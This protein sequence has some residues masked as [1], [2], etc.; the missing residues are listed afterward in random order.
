[1]QAYAATADA[2]GLQFFATIA[3][4]IP[5][6]AH[7][8]ALRIK[9]VLNNL[10]SNAIKFTEAGWVRIDLV[11][12]GEAD[13]GAVLEWRIADTGLGIPA[14][15]QQMLFQPFYQAHGSSGYAM[16]GTGLGLYICHSLCELMQGSITLDSSPPGQHVHLP[17]AAAGDGGR[18][19]P[20]R[21]R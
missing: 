6:Y 10:V 8:D 3:T 14:S 7:G 2:K 19:A 16:P 17:A 4:D 13:G 21:W 11:R 18:R 20:G 1:M 9:Q 5:V 12:A 15:Q